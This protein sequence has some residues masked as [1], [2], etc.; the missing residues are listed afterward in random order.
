MN[1]GVP[2]VGAEGYGSFVN[3]MMIS[4]EGFTGLV[5]QQGFAVLDTG[6]QHG[7]SGTADFE[8]LEK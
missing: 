4:G 5:L 8:K 6:A 2:G 3:F 1:F 7:V